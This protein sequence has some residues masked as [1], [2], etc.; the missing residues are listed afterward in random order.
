MVGLQL[1]FFTSV[2]SSKFALF[3]QLTLEVA[4]RVGKDV[5]LDSEV[6]LSVLVLPEG[7]EAQADSFTMDAMT[8]R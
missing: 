2:V 5:P 8:V 3:Q 1:T 4:V 7:G 6:S